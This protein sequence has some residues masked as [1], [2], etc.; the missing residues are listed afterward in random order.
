MEKKDR[1]N[2]NR[3]PGGNLPP[4]V[5]RPVAPVSQTKSASTIA[6]GVSSAPPVYR[7]FTAAAQR[8]PAIAAPP[9]YRPAPA[10][11]QPKSASSIPV[12]SGAP[13]IYCPQTAVQSKAVQLRP[14]ASVIQRSPSMRTLDANLAGIKDK[15][16]AYPGISDAS[17]SDKAPGFTYKGKTY[18]FTFIPDIY[19]LTDEADGKHH[20]FFKFGAEGLEDIHKFPHSISRKG[21]D[22]PL[23]E[24]PDKDLLKF[25]QRLFTKTLL[26]P[27]ALAI[28]LERKEQ[29]KKLADELWGTGGYATYADAYT[30]AR[31]A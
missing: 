5:Y 27:T 3:N 8:K 21:H 9:V 28:K 13:P 4:A 29:T 20:Y 26:H 14:A 31:N 10:V 16:R 19:H 17:P 11:S 12:R 15:T 24:L 1:S 30:D 7:P 23:S 18:H 6:P 22:H 2:P 25:V